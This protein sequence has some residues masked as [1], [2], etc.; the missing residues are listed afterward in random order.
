MSQIDPTSFLV[1]V[2]VAAVAGVLRTAL[3]RR[4]II[5]VVVI[6]LVLGIVIGPQVAD[7]AKVDQFTNFFGNLGLAMLF[8][9]AGYEIDFERIRG[10]PL[11]LA[12]IGWLLSLALAYGIG[13]AL[14]AAGVVLS[15]LY[16]GSAMA[17]TAMGTLV[18]ILSDSGEL[19]TRFGTR[20]LAIGAIGEF[21]PIAIVTLFLSSDHPLSEA[22]LLIGFVA[23][24]VLTGLL[25]VRSVWRGW[26]A[27]ERSLETSSQLAVRLMVVLVFGLVALAF[28]LG[29]DVLLGG[30]VAGLITRAALRGREVRA[31]ES[32]AAAL[33][34]GFLIPFFFITSG[35]KFDGSAL[36]ADPVSLL[37]VP[38][39]LALFLVVRGLPVLLLYRRQM[40]LRD[41]FALGFFASTQLP[42][43]VAITTIALAKHHMRSVTA[44]ALVAAG[45]L[46]TLIYPIVA[47]RLRGDS[48]DPLTAEEMEQLDSSPPGTIV[49]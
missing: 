19:K 14:A 6:E 33:G 49:T 7:I 28:E 3:E 24:A 43:V 45:I 18:P 4:L 37:R 11:E 21:G 15:L 38:L 8:F 47:V 9:F 1:I 30:F 13:G 48:Y 44:A 2:V 27:L 22:A 29:L 39:F 17:T 35:M 16:T 12:C 46:S 25:A 40:R 41:R 32:K 20:L 26:R 10:R 31:F 34:Y 36:L 5:P 23:V 42:M